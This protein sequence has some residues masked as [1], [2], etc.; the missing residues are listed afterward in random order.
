[1]IEIFSPAKI[2]LTLDVKPKN[3]GAN[4]HEIETIYHKLNWGD[5]LTIQAA[6]K[7]EILGNFDCSTKNNLIYKAWRLIVDLNLNRDR[8]QNSNIEIE[9]GLER[10]PA[11]KVF[12]DKKI[13]SGGG[14]GGGSSNAAH[15][16]LGYFKLFNLG[17]TPEVLVTSLSDLGKDI[18]FFLQPS[19]C[20][21]GSNFGEKISP[22]DFDFSQQT[23][24]LYFPP[25]KANTAAA[26][27]R[28]SKFD[29]N[30]TQKFLQQPNL[31]NCGNT[32]QQNIEQKKY[33]KLILTGSG[34]TFYSF[35]K[36]KVPEYKII[37]TTLL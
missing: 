35:G 19:P 14:L 24:H 11:V 29:T 28:L 31:K 9:T 4:F 17:E 8:S 20:A 10:L 12:V 30:F 2:N 34:S 15:F 18:P 36:I 7:F 32:F 13:P 26:Y 25:F 33:S 6:K 27:G 5:S 16:V 3:I 1:M 37:E 21:L 23:V 22:L